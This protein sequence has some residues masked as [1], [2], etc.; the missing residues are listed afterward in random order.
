MEDKKAFSKFKLKE[1]KDEGEGSG[2]SGS[3]GNA[4]SK[5]FKPGFIFNNQQQQVQK[6]DDHFDDDLS[7][8]DYEQAIEAASQQLVAKKAPSSFP[9]KATASSSSLSSSSAPK[10]GSSSSS[11]ESAALE[12][13]NQ[14]ASQ[15]VDFASTKSS[16]SSTHNIPSLKGS[17]TIL[18]NSNQQ[19]NP[20][21]QSLRSVRYYHVIH[22]EYIYERVNELSRGGGLYQLKVLLVMVDHVVYEAHL[23]ELTILAVRTNWTLLVA[24]TYEEAARHIEHLRVNAEKPA[25]VIMGRFDDGLGC[26][27]T[28]TSTSSTG[29]SSSSSSKAFSMNQSLVDALTSVKSVNRTDAATLLGSF[30]TFGDLVR[31][32]TD[33][34]TCCPGISMV[35]AKRLQTLFQK[36]FCSER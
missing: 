21:L 20:L 29:N 34:L 23:K 27:T 24:W 10:A 32:N 3:G 19:K 13:V 35:K 26:G 14:V 6:N 4:A 12:R 30:D 1:K 15:A 17:N 25:D 28:S 31:A 18:V 2:P 22:P 5:Y 7:D 8:T 36:P 9:E 16:S 33:L 11:V